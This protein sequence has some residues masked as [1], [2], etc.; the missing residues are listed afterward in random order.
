M[1]RQQQAKSRAAAVMA[2]MSLALL[3]W[4]VPQPQ[5]AH[6]AVTNLYASPTGSGSTC[7]LSLPC[8]LTGARDKARTLTSG[9]TGNLF[10][11]LLDGTYRLTDTFALGTSDSGSNGYSV[12]YRNYAGATPVLSG[13]DVIAGWTLD[14]PIRSVYKATGVATAFRQLY[15]DGD[16]EVR[17]R[18]PDMADP[19][20]KAPYYTALSTSP[21]YKV[22]A[23]EIASWSNFGQVE[24]VWLA[25]WHEKRARL[26]SYAVSGS[27]ATL[28]FASPE[29]DSIVL[30]HFNQDT[31]YYYFENAYEFLSEPG[32][33]YWDDAA[34]TVYYIPRSGENLSTATVVAPRLDTLV[35]IEGT[36][37]APAHHIEIRGITFEHSN[38]ARPNT[39]GYLNNQAGLELQT[40][41]GQ[42]VPGA[43][44]IANANFV[45]IEGNTFRQT[46]AHGL[47]ATGN[48]YRNTV[49]GNTF[50]DLAGGGIYFNSDTSSYDVISN[51]LV[52]KAGQYYTDAVGIL[53]TR[54]DHMSID[55]N[56]VRDMP[57]TGISIGWKWDDTDTGTEYNAVQY[58]YVHDV[59]KLHDDGAGIYTLGYMPNSS[60]ENNYIASVTA[61]VYN[62]TYPIVGIYLDGGSA[63]KTVQNNVLDGTIKA[64][65]GNNT[66]NH[67]NAIQGNY[68]NTTLGTISNSNTVTGNTYVSGS[69][70]GTAADIIAGAGR[71]ANVA[72]NKSASASSSYDA[73]YT[74][75]KAVDGS[76][77]EAGWSPDGAAGTYPS[78][79]VDLGASYRIKKVEIVPRLGTI[80]NMTTRRNFEVRASNNSDMSG[81][82]VLSCYGSPFPH[83]ST[84]S[85]IV[86]NVN[87]YRY[88]QLVKT[89]PEYFYL[90]EVRIYH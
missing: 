5:T 23:S 82:V 3:G 77:D 26:S 61:S 12:I 20:T 46:G 84:W 67:D 75:G 56:E 34:D 73:T 63:N 47:T 64:F 58:N 57:Y 40:D 28:T 38:W 78:W 51:N 49:V 6:A 62:G 2:A 79:K 74:P 65:Y 50:T 59:M 60:I 54:P 30:D 17:A 45:R 83:W 41:N 4:F 39:K 44:Q 18:Q 70:S 76:T 68:Y 22:N 42:A 89:A 33:W 36:Q 66:P 1:K 37:T 21:S 14:D 53:A 87:A 80:N 15:V 32:E 27:E 90:N 52:E 7:S 11:N 72:L 24:F 25:H 69:W 71:V 19:A 29:K 48:L 81:Y 16:R 85:A 9:M 55:F 8:S 86:T 31:T 35:K 10:V 43:L 13:G 88:I